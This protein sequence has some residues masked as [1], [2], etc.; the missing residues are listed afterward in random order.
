MNPRL[1]GYRMR[2]YALLGG[3]WLVVDHRE[4]EVSRSE[5]DVK[6]AGR[7]E[8]YDGSTLYFTEVVIIQSNQ[9]TK[10]DYSYQ[11]RNENDPGFFRYDCESHGRPQPYH[12]KHAYK[13]PSCHIDRAPDLL[14]ILN[15]IELILS[16][17]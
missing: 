17:E 12:H 13:Q 14:D 16:T 2:L 6:I 8:I 11:F 4:D 10:I 7:A 5:N 3:H 15:E 1:E 9:P